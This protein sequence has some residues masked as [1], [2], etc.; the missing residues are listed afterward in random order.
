MVIERAAGSYLYDSSG[1]AILDF[2]SGQMSSILGHSHPEIVATVRHWVGELDHLSTMSSRSSITPYVAVL[3]RPPSLVPNTSE[4][5]RILEL[6]LAELLLPEVF[7]EERWQMMGAER[8]IFFFELVGDTIWGATA[9]MLRQLLAI[10]TDV[11]S[12]DGVEA[13]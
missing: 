1:R 12:R 5:E 9:R 7:R 8:P 2:A 6:P 4:V 3:G 10:A 11:D 13:W